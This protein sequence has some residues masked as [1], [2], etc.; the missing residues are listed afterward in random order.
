MSAQSPFF[1]CL[2]FET[3]FLFQF[4]ELAGTVPVHLYTKQDQGQEVET[5][6]LFLVSLQYVLLLIAISKLTL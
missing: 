3:D 5:S 2:N 4:W 1:I 6:L